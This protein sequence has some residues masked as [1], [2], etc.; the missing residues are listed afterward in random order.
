MMCFLGHLWIDH[1][2]KS[3][4]EQP[5]FNEHLDLGFVELGKITRELLEKLVHRSRYWKRSLRDNGEYINSE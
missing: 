3:I 1:E 2:N 4:S 5:P